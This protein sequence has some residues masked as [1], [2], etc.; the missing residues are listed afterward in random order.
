MN[1]LHMTFLTTK[2]F[3]LLTSLKKDLIVLQ[4]CFY[5]VHICIYIRIHMYSTSNDAGEH[6][7]V[8][9]HVNSITK[10]S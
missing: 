5:L 1:L 9:T 6:L 7:F 2:L 3:F 10:I 4:R 8:G